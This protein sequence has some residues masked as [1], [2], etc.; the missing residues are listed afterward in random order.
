MRGGSLSKAAM[1]WKPL[2]GLCALTLLL[3][4]ASGCGGV[5]EIDPVSGEGA[6]QGQSVAVDLS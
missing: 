2:L 1:T 4:M 5:W 6:A 3:V